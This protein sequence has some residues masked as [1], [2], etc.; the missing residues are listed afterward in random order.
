MIS[1]FVASPSPSQALLA[2]PSP[3]GGEG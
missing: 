2:F 3:A 1:F